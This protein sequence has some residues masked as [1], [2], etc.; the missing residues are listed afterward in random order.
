MLCV[1]VRFLGEGILSVGKWVGKVSGVHRN[2]GAEKAGHIGQ[3][4]SR[5]VVTLPLVA[6]LLCLTSKITDHPY[7]HYYYCGMC[8]ILALAQYCVYG[9]NNVRVR[10]PGYTL[11]T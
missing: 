7:P 1:A 6:T 3:E 5:V 4:S 8:H 10:I 11:L 9:V 2:M